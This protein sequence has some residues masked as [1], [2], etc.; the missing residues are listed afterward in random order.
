MAEQIEIN[1]YWMMEEYGRV[2]VVDAG[3][4]PDTV[5]VEVLSG[6][7]RGELREVYLHDLASEASANAAL[8]ALLNSFRS[9]R[10]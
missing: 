5:T 2:K 9:S 10:G 7:Y 3:H 6:E 1:K 8:S 4:F